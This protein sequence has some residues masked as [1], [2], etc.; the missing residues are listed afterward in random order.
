MKKCIYCSDPIQLNVGPEEENAQQPPQSH[1][2]GLNSVFQPSQLSTF[3][4]DPDYQSGSSRTACSSA[5]DI[6]TESDSC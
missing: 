3:S 4:D 2:V 1:S 6:G 5:M